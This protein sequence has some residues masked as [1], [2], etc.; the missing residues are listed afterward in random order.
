[1]RNL[2]IA[3]FVGALF[4]TSA[5]SQSVRWFAMPAAAPIGQEIVF[6]LQN[7]TPGTL[8]VRGST[9]FAVMD[10]KQSIIF[11]PRGLP[12]TMPVAPGKYAL[13]VWNQL[14]LARKQVAPGLYEG[15][16]DYATSP[17]G[18]SIRVKVQVQVDNVLLGAW[19]SMTPGGTVQYS[20]NSAPAAGS[21]SDSARAAM[22]PAWAARRRSTWSGTW[23]IRY[24]RRPDERYRSPDG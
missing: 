18:K 17:S 22:P 12:I 23:V 15:V 14:D 13:W 16:L 6:T 7:Q 8:Y 11:Q 4:A 19:G 20:L 21:P 1:M 24:K 3:M 2:F 9:P 5:A 10:A